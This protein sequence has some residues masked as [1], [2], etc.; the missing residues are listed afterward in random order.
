M[1]TFFC[2]EDYRAYL[3]LLGEWCDL[4][5]VSIWAYCL[6][7]NHPGF[8]KATP[9]QAFMRFSFRQPLTAWPA[10]SAELT[11]DTQGE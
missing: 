9:G 11:G 6:M 7:P 10:P 4:Y 5:E 2:D 8:A 1:Q 3:S